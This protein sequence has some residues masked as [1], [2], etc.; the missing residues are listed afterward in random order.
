MY[1]V[2]YVLFISWLNLVFFHAPNQVRALENKVRIRGHREDHGH[3]YHKTANQVLARVHSIDH[4]D[5]R[6]IH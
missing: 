5:S 6:E 1:Q 4:S 2:W 3:R